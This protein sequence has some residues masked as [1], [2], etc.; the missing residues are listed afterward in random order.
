MF[1]LLFSLVMMWSWQPTGWWLALTDEQ[2]TKRGTGSDRKR[3]REERKKEE[4][5]LRSSWWRASSFFVFVDFTF[6]FLL[7]LISNSIL[8]AM[9]QLSCCP[10]ISA[11]FKKHGDVQFRGC[12]GAE[13]SRSEA[14]TGLASSWPRSSFRTSRRLACQS[15]KSP[16]LWAGITL[17]T[18]RLPE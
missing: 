17:T 9:M 10:P 18:L 8:W 13:P 3:G 16:G 5:Y 12:A 2:R 14:Q 6:G 1:G 11:D 4:R 7:P 15:R